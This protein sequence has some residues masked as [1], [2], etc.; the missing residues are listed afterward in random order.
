MFVAFELRQVTSPGLPATTE[1]VVL[2]DGKVF[3]ASLPLW[4]Q[5]VSWAMAAAELR[6]HAPTAAR[7]DWQ[8]SLYR[9]A[10]RDIGYQLSQWGGPWALPDVRRG[11]VAVNA[12]TPR[13]WSAL[14]GMLVPT[15][16]G[17][18]RGGVAPHPLLAGWV[19][20]AG[21]ALGLPMWG[22]EAPGR[23]WV[24]GPAETAAAWASFPLKA[25]PAPLAD[26]TRWRQFHWD[27]VGDVPGLARRLARSPYPA[28]EAPPLVVVERRWPDPLGVGLRSVWIELVQE[29]SATLKAG[30]WVAS[31]LRV[32]WEGE[33]TPP[34]EWRRH[35]SVGV[36]DVTTLLLRILS[37]VPLQGVAPPIRVAI[38]ANQLAAAPHPQM[39]WW[40]SPAPRGSAA[41]SQALLTSMTREES[42]RERRLAL[43]DPWRSAAR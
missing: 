33:A 27:R 34:V 29:L 19:A 7:C 35:W 18:I 9:D 28:V 22:A 15:G 13:D 38:A 42:L 5:G 11:W 1:Y 32:V 43:W 6:W 8:A 25:V 14:A 10:Q 20:R 4:D 26:H 41:Q 12:P 36:Q 2:R 39:S 37:L 3:D 30:R 31:G 24:V 16:A 21:G 40:E 17:W 23:C